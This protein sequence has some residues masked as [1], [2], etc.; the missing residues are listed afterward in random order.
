MT[1]TENK[2]QWVPVSFK[3]AFDEYHCSNNEKVKVIYNHAEYMIEDLLDEMRTRPIASMKIAS[4]GQWFIFTEA[5]EKKLY[6]TPLIIGKFPID[7]VIEAMEISELMNKLKTSDC[8]VYGNFNNLWAIEH[9]DLEN[10]KYKI[11]ARNDSL[12]EALKN[13]DQQEWK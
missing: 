10:V 1:N 5:V 7:K 4:F 8:C 3:E 12:L 9:M 11:I 13:A 6:E 2:K